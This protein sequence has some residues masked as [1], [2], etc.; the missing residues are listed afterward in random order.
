[1]KLYGAVTAFAAMGLVSVS[2]AQRSKFFEPAGFQRPREISF[3]GFDMVDA[4][5]RTIGPQDKME[6][7]NGRVVTAQEFYDSLNRIERGLNKVGHS[8]RETTSHIVLPGN[9]ADEGLV[10]RQ[11][12]DYTR[13][14][15]PAVTSFVAPKRAMTHSKLQMADLATRAGKHTGKFGTVEA[16]GI[17]LVLANGTSLGNSPSTSYSWGFDKSFGDNSIGVRLKAGVTVS[18]HSVNSANPPNLKGATT[19]ISATFDGGCRGTLLGGTFD[20]LTGKCQ[21][22]TSSATGK[23]SVGWAL[24][25]AGYQVLSDNKSFDA[26]YTWSDS[27]SIPFQKQSQT[28]E[29]PIFG[30]FACSGFV[31]V[32]GEAGIKANLALN[33]I[34]AE[35]EVIPFVKAGVFGEVD[36]GLDAEVAS[37]WGG[38]H[39]D[40]TLVDDE[41]T[42]GA[43][44]GIVALP[45]NKV[46]WRDELYVTNKLNLFQGTLSLVAHVF[47]PGGAKLQDFSFPFYTIRG[48]TDDRTLYQ[49]GTTNVL[50]WLGN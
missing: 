42:L 29:F 38:L 3:R 7:S 48:Y 33:P 50:S 15:K 22:G 11:F 34:Y 14:A 18:A 41:F 31:G 6:L 5:G 23:V 4:A 28:M 44:I 9:Y 16:G 39:A 21:V 1:M 12:A 24:N 35:A 8:L 19:T 47:G 17:P 40:L 46:G 13:S 20:I 37:A 25:V 30:P 27:Y 26:S 2:M 43:N 10:Q 49:T 32:E 45:N 36:A